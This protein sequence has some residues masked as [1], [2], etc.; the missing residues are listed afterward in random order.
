MTAAPGG[1]DALAREDLEIAAQVRA[2]LGA[3]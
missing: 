2:T 1:L 3:P